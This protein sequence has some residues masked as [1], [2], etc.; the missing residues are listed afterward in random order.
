MT[1]A[2]GADDKT[3]SET[4]VGTVTVED[5]GAVVDAG[6]CESA[7][8]VTAE[9]ITMPVICDVAVAPACVVSSP[10]TGTDDCAGAEESHDCAPVRSVGS[11]CEL[12]GKGTTVV[13]SESLA[14]ASKDT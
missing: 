13:C 2:A 11:E 5:M 3:D 7:M 1:P 6:G 10:D 4:G 8:D 12:R 14:S 9:S